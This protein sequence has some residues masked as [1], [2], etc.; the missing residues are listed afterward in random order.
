M[1]NSDWSTD[2]CSSYLH[3]LLFEGAQ[4]ALLDIDH[5]TY[6]FVT[7]SNCI[8]GAAS[9]G[10]GVGP[11]T[12]DYVLGSAKAYTARVGSGPFPTELPDDTVIER[13]TGGESVCQYVE[14][15]VCAET[16]KKKR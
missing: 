13:A 1:R 6:P 4:G 5:G 16:I 15:S 11:Q 10:A 14:C 7:S 9:A 8:A 12:L 3:K 2:V